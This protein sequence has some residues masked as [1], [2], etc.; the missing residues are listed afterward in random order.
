MSDDL[1]SKWLNELGIEDETPSTAMDQVK[2][3]APKNEKESET[4]SS[5]SVSERS[6]PN[7]S[8]PEGQ[9]LNNGKEPPNSSNSSSEDLS[10]KSIQR[11]ANSLNSDVTRDRKKAISELEKLLL[12]GKEH[13]STFDVEAISLETGHRLQDSSVL[14]EEWVSAFIVALKP[15]LKRLADKVESIRVSAARLVQTYVYFIF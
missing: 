4:H 14:D 9:V 5:S 13:L 7:S 11:L 2:V 10:P 8:T 1:M 12:A 3:S 15:L 6:T